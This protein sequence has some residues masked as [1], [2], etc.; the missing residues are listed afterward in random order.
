MATQEVQQQLNEVQLQFEEK[1]GHLPHTISQMLHYCKHNKLQYKFRDIKQWWPHRA[2]PTNKPEAPAINATPNGHSAES[3]TQRMSINPPNKSNT[4]E[5]MK[6]AQS[7]SLFSPMYSS[8]GAST[9]ITVGT[10]STPQW[11]TFESLN[12]EFTDISDDEDTPLQTPNMLAL[13]PKDSEET[14][15]TVDSGDMSAPIAMD[16]NSNG[17]TAAPYIV[18]DDEAPPLLVTIDEKTEEYD[19]F[20]GA[21]EFTAMQLKML[22]NKKSSIRKLSKHRLSMPVMTS[23]PQRFGLLTPD[24]FEQEPS[25]SAASAASMDSDGPPMLRPVMQRSNSAGNSAAVEDWRMEGLTIW[26]NHKEEM[27]ELWTRWRHRKDLT[28]QPNEHE[29]DNDDHHDKEND[30]DNSTANDNDIDNDNEPPAMTIKKRISGLSIGV[31]KKTSDDL[32]VDD[33]K[34]Q[35]DSYT[36]QIDEIELA[37][38]YL[39]AEIITTEETYIGGLQA[40]LSEFVNPMIEQKLINKKYKEVLTCN[41]PHLLQFHR[42]FLQHMIEATDSD[43]YDSEDEEFFDD[44]DRPSSC[45]VAVFNKLCN[46][47]FAEMYANYTKEYQKM[48]NIYAKYNK[49]KKVQQFLKQKRKEKKPLSNHLILPIQRCTRYL[50]LLQELKK[51]TPNEHR[52]YDEL[53]QVLTKIDETVNTINEKQRAIEN[54]ST[55]LQIQETLHGLSTNIVRPHRMFIRQFCFTLKKAKKRRQ[56]FLFNDILIIANLKL[57]AKCIIELQTL[58]IKPTTECDYRFK[59]F[60]LKHEGVYEV[61][62]DQ[63][64]DMNDF[65][66]LVQEKRFMVHQK[67]LKSVGANELADIIKQASLSQSQLIQDS[68]HMGAKRYSHK[69]QTSMSNVTASHV[70]NGSIE[71]IDEEFS[72]QLPDGVI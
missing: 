23:S 2:N 6:L 38:K 65:V 54:M 62:P 57:K 33:R 51:I 30:N 34:T 7:T 37:R 39:I 36:E 42:Q 56:F 44:E 48:L 20:M 18:E 41:I 35:M 43:Y 68:M 70:S 19:K 64:S 52:E 53:E 16:A 3:S 71:T 46:E 67:S 72:M 26:S 55:C 22:G 66:Q 5:S 58:D 28:V 50:L 27:D 45:L 60:S 29:N 8:D 11:D 59:L 14:I 13:G 63:K 69:A 49:N 32:Y 17:D 10:V 25:I 15:N 31:P 61:Q 1:M 4:F 47:S 9:V 40:L 24:D 12:F 21:N